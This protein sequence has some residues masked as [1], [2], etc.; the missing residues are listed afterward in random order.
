MTSCQ[1]KKPPTPCSIH[2]PL[3]EHESATDDF[4]SWPQAVQNLHTREL[5]MWAHRNPDLDIIEQNHSIDPGRRVTVTEFHY[6][7]KKT[8]AAA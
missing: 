3:Y 8:E 5:D 2:V 1:I 7:A 4:A 6:A